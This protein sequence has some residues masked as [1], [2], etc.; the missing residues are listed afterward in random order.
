MNEPKTLSQIK[1]IARNENKGD[2]FI[3]IEELCDY[4]EKLELQCNKPTGE[5]DKDIKKKGTKNG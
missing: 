5:P 2:L 1:G 4:I 3:A